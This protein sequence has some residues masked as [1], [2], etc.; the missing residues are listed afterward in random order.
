[1]EVCPL[2]HSGSRHFAVVRERIYWECSRC[3]GIFCEQKALPTDKYEETRYRQHNNDVND[4]KYQEFTS[5][6][7]KAVLNDFDE[8][9]TGLDFGAGTG[10][11]ISK[12]LKDNAYNIVPYDP[13]FANYPELL[14]STYDYIVCCEVAEHFHNPKKEFL[15]LRK[16]LKPQGKLYLMTSIYSAEINFQKWYYKD[17]DTHVFFYTQ[18]TFEYIKNTFGFRDLTII[19]NF[20]LLSN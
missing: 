6:I 18:Q 15:L 4:V 16:M 14:N 9:H 1:M 20:I 13:F 12:M 11:V 2:C 8:N 5:P 7:W 17:D 3:K 19:Q 10:P